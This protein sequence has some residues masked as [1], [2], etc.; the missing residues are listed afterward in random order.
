MRII[1]RKTLETFWQ[2]YPDSEQTLKAWYS[3]AK[4][5]A[6]HSPNDI[7]AKY[8]HASIV[9]DSRVVFNICGN[10]YRLVVKIAYPFSCI[11][12]RFIGTHKQYDRIEVEK[13]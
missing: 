2:S 8:G 6:W 12:I 10:K 7:K 5:A 4:H 13:I 11:Y 9:G 3:E 1:A